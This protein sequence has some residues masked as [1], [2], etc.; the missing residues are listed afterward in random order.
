[1]VSSFN[2]DRSGILC[3]EL[4]RFILTF[5]PFYVLVRSEIVSDS[6]LIDDLNFYIF[7][8]NSQIYFT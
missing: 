7:T 8:L 2:E 1:M 4:I 6:C 3:R 5:T